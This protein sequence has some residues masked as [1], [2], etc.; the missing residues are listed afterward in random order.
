MI[1]KTYHDDGTIGRACEALTEAGY[2][3]PENVIRAFG[4]AGILIRERV[5]DAV[6]EEDSGPE[7]EYVLMALVGIHKQVVTFQE[8]P[9][10]MYK[11]IRSHPRTLKMA[12]DHWDSLDGPSAI[13]VTVTPAP[14]KRE[15]PPRLLPEISVKRGGIDFGATPTPPEK[16]D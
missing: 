5:P 2:A 6:V 14:Y 1:D 15:G 8:R 16:S 3:Y 13:E 7:E 4:N 9:S 12:V 11:V 10:G